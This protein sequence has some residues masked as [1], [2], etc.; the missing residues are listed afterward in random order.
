MCMSL[1]QGMGL[2]LCGLLI[3]AAVPGTAHAAKTSASMV[4]A[5]AKADKPDASGNQTVTITLEIEKPWHLYAN[6]VKN[7]DLAAAQTTVKIS[8][9]VKPEAVKVEYPVGKVY[10]DKIIGTFMIY[11]GTVT[12]KAQVRRAKGD[13]SPLE[14]AIDVNACK[15]KVC[16]LPA[17][18]KLTVP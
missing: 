17:T 12:I 2:L 1:R 3:G 5:S 11:E 4:K 10:K 16:L 14:V 9:K 13:T 8:A 18:I 15:E 6:P 7:E